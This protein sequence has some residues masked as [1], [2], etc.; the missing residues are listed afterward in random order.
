MRFA[1]FSSFTATTA[2][3]LR[4]SLSQSSLGNPSFKK[5]FF[6]TSS[7]FSHAKSNKAVNAALTAATLTASVVLAYTV[8][9]HSPASV[10][11]NEEAEGLHSPHF[12]WSHHGPLNSFDHASI[13]RGYQVYKEICATCHSLD[14]IAYRNLVGVSH[15]EKEAKAL[16]ADIE[17]VDGPNEEGE[18]YTR[19]GILSDYH[20]RPY[21][22][23]NA[24][25]AANAGSY[26]P[27]LSLIIK[28]RHGGEDYVFSLLTGYCEPPAGVEIRPGLNYNPYFPGGAIGMARNIY[29][30][31]VEYEDGTPATATQIAKDVTTF[32]AWASEPELDDRKRIGLKAMIILSG[33]TFLSLWM[34]RFKWST[35]KSRQLVFKPPRSDA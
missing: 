32:L 31:V 22:N 15:T 24:A 19:P 13:R 23:E 2:T 20:P 12:P 21:P 14:L 17:V 25:R 6:S 16:A 30:E 28:A 7:S 11:A 3:R 29:D 10:H 1:T 27:D 8:S 34:K 4:N 26:P 18:M 5:S 35:L 33:L 9:I